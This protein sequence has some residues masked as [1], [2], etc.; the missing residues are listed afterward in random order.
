MKEES[1]WLSG[2]LKMSKGKNQS[3]I[4]TFSIMLKI[5]TALT[6]ALASLFANAQTETRN[7]SPF[8]KLEITDGVEVI[9]TQ[10]DTFSLKAE[11]SDALGLATLLT[12][13]KNKTLRISCD[14]NGC[15]MAKVYV[16]APEI[17]SIKAGRDSKVIIADRMTAGKFELNLN[18]NATFN[19]IVTT[20]AAVLKGR[21][22]AIFNIR[23]TANSVNANF[24]SG[25]KVNL[26]GTS[27]KSVIR[28][29]DNALCNARNF[30]NKS[31]TVIAGNDAEVIVSANEKIE[32]NVSDEASVRYFGLPKT[33]SVNPEAIAIVQHNNGQVVANE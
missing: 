12:E 18:S 24:Q 15:E 11:A 30:I 7:V 10:S 25:A 32:I 20:G 5:I 4:K 22:G 3:S 8:N 1:Q 9:Y 17:V 21:S 14:G 13:S 31:V 26:S 6:A 2:I 19:G 33:A 28:T 29:T 27:D 16:T 23:L